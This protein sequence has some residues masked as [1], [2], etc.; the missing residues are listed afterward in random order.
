MIDWTIDKPFKI[1]TQSWITLLLTLLLT[2]NVLPLYA[3]AGDLDPTFGTQGRMVTTLG[4]GVGKGS[5]LVRQG[6]GKLIVGGG[7]TL[8]RIDDQGQ[9]DP[10]FGY[11]GM[12]PTLPT[13]TALSLQS[14]QKLLAAGYLLEE[15]LE[16][17]SD[18]IVERFLP[19]GKL[20]P[21]FGD[22]GMVRLE[23]KYAT[24][25]QAYAIVVSTDDSFLVL[26]RLPQDLY[27][28]YSTPVVI[29]F[30][31][32]GAIDTSF[33]DQGRLFLTGLAF[34]L[35]LQADGRIW[36]AGNT[37]QGGDTTEINLYCFLPNGA[38]D[39]SFDNDGLLVT[40]FGMALNDI[41]D[42][43]IQPDGKIVLTAS[44]GFGVYKD[45]DYVVLRLNPDGS[46][47]SSFAGDGKAVLDFNGWADYAYT[48]ALQSDGKI[49]SSGVAGNAEDAGSKIVFVR[50]NLDGS[51]DTSFD[52]DGIWF[53][54][55][56]QRH[57]SFY[58]L[59]LQPDDKVVT[60][61][62]IG[63]RFTVMRYSDQATFDSTFAQNG[64]LALSTGDSW[65][66]GLAAQPDGKLLVGGYISTDN[67]DSNSEWTLLRYLPD[68]TIDSNFGTAGK[69]VTHFYAD[70]S[71]NRIQSIVLQPDSKI[72]AAGRAFLAGGFWGLPG[73]GLTR[74][75]ADGS[76]D[77]TFE[78]DGKVDLRIDL[79]MDDDTHALALQP[80]GKIVVG[81]STS[82]ENYD[83]FAL[84]RV[85]ADGTLDTTFGQ[86]GMA[87]ADFAAESTLRSLVRQSDGKWLVAGR[88]YDP[89]NYTYRF[90]LA[91]FL[92]DGVLDESFGEGGKVTASFGQS[93][94]AYAL[95]IQPDDKIVVGGDA[96]S[97]TSSG[98]FNFTLLRYNSDGIPDTTFAQ[99]GIASTSLGEYFDHKLRVL[100]LQG[101][102]IL[103]A[104]G[105]SDGYNRDFALLR[106]NADGSLDMDFAGDGAITT[107]F[108]SANDTIYA[109]AWQSEAKLIA[110]GSTD[111]TFALARYEMAS[112]TY[113]V[114]LPSILQ[115]GG[116]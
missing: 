74:Y 5:A 94:G 60:A 36:V 72:V 3:V 107:D 2:L 112:K 56:N 64:E 50:L 109:L 58:T 104:G 95:L 83:S 10:S 68:G 65:V 55:F 80:D 75:L 28:Q 24:F 91:R 22:A 99:N 101:N 93:D 49:I 42:L 110:A 62:E 34:L 43:A 8:V 19:D 41:S 12:L 31:P 11:A 45:D 37:A 108:G 82:A 96:D 81:G 25:V 21:T 90:G 35:R 63:N 113:R 30:H 116:K 40:Q 54:D 48:L 17:V 26:G 6:D 79:Q 114:F 32:D 78:N 92:A 97:E 115:N 15:G 51:L 111:R 14:N 53:P 102:Q 4:V 85:N 105:V 88:V 44:A 71:N 18:L 20:D 103:A 89:E 76:P 106:Y 70:E 73:L 100:S 69:T 39:P 33:A 38:P 52:Q 84:V 86:A 87:I 13:I 66:R 16:T 9:L 1:R 46:L 59:L 77:P 98:H 61:G 7:H 23:H 29:K 67:Y 57:P 27:S 47:D